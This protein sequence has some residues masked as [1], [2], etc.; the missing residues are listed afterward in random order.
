MKLSQKILNAIDK[1]EEEETN[2]FVKFLTD[3]SKE[4]MNTK[5]DL[6]AAAPGHHVGFK[7]G[8]KQARHAIAEMILS[9]IDAFIEAKG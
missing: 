4:A 5:C 2:R 6:S 9:K 1:V 8:H 7:Y 3:L